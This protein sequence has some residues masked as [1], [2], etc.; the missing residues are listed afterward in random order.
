[1]YL[2]CNPYLG[3]HLIKCFH[4]WYNKRHRLQ[5]CVSSGSSWYQ[6]LF[7]SQVMRLSCIKIV[8][9]SWSPRDKGLFS[10]GHT[11]KHSSSIRKSESENESCSVMSN[12][13]QPHGLY[14][15]RN[16]PGQNTEVGSHFLLQGIFSTQGSN[17]GLPHSRWILY[18]LSH[19]GSPRRLEWVACPFFIGSFWPR[20]QTGVSYISGG[21]FT[22]W[23]TREAH[24]RKS[25]SFMLKKKKKKKIPF[26]S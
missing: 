26:L 13:L 24:F 1:M 17:P 15:P 11:S 20:N 25:A 4:L 2:N 7:I 14:S 18:Q 23:A 21:F 10:T 16:S 8:P 5:L 19:K 22:S 3:K 12:S 9:P 6:I